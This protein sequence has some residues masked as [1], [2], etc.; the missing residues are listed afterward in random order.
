MHRARVALLW[1][2]FYPDVLPVLEKHCLR[3][4]RDGELAPMALDTYEKARPYARAI[5]NA[6][7][8]RTMPPWFA[9][10]KPREFANDPRLTAAEI[11]IIKRWS[12]NPKSQGA[13]RAAVI[14]ESHLKPDISFTMPAPFQV[15]A[16]GTV[17]YQHFIVP[18][19]FTADRWVQAIEVRPS[20]PA[21][22]HHAVVFVR[23]PKSIWLRGY[24][25]G[26]AFIAKGAALAG[27]SA[28]DEVIGTY[29]P[30]NGPVTLPDDHAKLIP[31]GS[32]LIFQIHYTPSGRATPDTTTIGLVFAK[33]PPRYR[34]YSAAIAR[35]DFEIP[36][37]ARSH[38]VDIAFQV[39]APASI[40]ALAPHMHLRGRA[41]RVSVDEK[42]VLDVPRYEFNWQLVYRPARQIP[43]ARG[44]RIDVEAAFDN[45]G[46][47][48]SVRWGEQSNEEMAVCFVDF[49]IPAAASPNELFTPS[50]LLRRNQP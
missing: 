26:S 8:R 33:Q 4:H 20:A 29:L 46:N 36:P 6:V 47:P 37:R 28:F 32:D 25:P 17:D 22:V 24:A 31:A 18:T 48:N 34:V 43:L 40:F 38:K 44:A 9:D 21:V 45:S 50:K 13:P 1:T 39:Q 11:D 5:R 16:Q 30:G 35:G 12:D 19:N 41:M 49:V 14:A 10:S 3:C 23:P 42:I 2:A 15:P 7:L 27:L